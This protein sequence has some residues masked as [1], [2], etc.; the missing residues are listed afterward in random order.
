MPTHVALLRGINVGGHNKVAMQDL[1]AVVTS[2]GHTDVAT[3]IQSGN[4]V[5]TTTKRSTAALA[6]EL[7]RA[8]AD[9]VGVRPRVVVLSRAEVAK[10]VDD[11]P[12]PA[13]RDLKKLHAIFLT[14]EAGPDI[15]ERVAAAQEQAA[16]KGSRDSATVV[17]RT[18]YLH[19]PDGFGRSELAALLTRGSGGGATGVAGTARNWAT[20]T[21]L[22][23]L[24]GA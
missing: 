4:V 19:T 10:V 6:T 16:G 9:A 22:L 7:E 8:I 15:V 23:D 3:Y 17:G 12:Y 20:V 5:F 21:K 2:L 13:E 18:L 14:D 11:N 1:R 24:F